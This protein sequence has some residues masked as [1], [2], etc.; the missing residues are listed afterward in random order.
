MVLSGNQPDPLED[1]HPECLSG[2]GTDD[3]HSISFLSDEVSPNQQ[4]IS[5]FID[6]VVLS[7]STS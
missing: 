5:S 2:Y 6:V 3:V 4:N 1:F 7:H